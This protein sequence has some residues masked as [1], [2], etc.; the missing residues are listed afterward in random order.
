[1][2]NHVPLTELAAAVE[3]AVQQVLGKHG[4]VPI[5]KLWVGFV[6][7]EEIANLEAAAKVATQLG[8]EAGVNVQASVAQV[9]G[10]SAEERK[11][12]LAR[13]GHIIGLVYSPKIKQ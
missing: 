12:Q 7:P 3:N 8:R 2:P 4:A 6:A 13:P 10:A 5:D 1:M 9:A 11:A